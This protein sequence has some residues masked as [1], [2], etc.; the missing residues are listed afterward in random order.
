MSHRFLKRS[1]RL[2]A[3]TRKRD[4]NMPDDVDV[5]FCAIY[6]STVNMTQIN[7]I[8]YKKIRQFFCGHI[9]TLTPTKHVF[10]IGTMAYDKTL[11][12]VPKTYLNVILLYNIP[13]YKSNTIKI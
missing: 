13:L 8:I 2:N 5:V 11:S 12:H 7:Y 1:R 9:F 4:S 6:N 3:F 10:E